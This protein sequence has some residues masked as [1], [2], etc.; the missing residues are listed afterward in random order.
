VT[1]PTPLSRAI[2]T[3]CRP[4][5]V[6]LVMLLALVGCKSNGQTDLVEREMRQQEDQ[7]YA[8]QDYLNNYQQLLCQT[9]AENEFLK[10]QL[11]DGQP[12]R[13]STAPKSDS[14]KSRIKSPSQ[15]P[16]QTPIPPSPKTNGP[17]LGDPEATPEVPKLD[18]DNPAVPP[19]R[20]T[21]AED[22]RGPEGDDRELAA[23]QKRPKHVVET[24]SYEVE[25]KEP[26]AAA[27]PM[28]HETKAADAQPLAP[29]E[30]TQQVIL[31]GQVVADEE[32]GS[33]HMLVDVQPQIASGQPVNFRGRLS[34]M[35]MDPNGEQPTPSLARW[36]FTADELDQATVNST[37]GPQFEFPLQLPSGV[38]TD[39]PVELWVRLLPEAGGKV[40]AHATVDLS[41][42][43]QF[44]SAGPPTA[45]VVQRAPQIVDSSVT[46]AQSIQAAICESG[47]Q[48]ARPDQ[49]APQLPNQVSAGSGWR[50]ATESIPQ[51]EAIATRV[52]SPMPLPISAR[53]PD[54]IRKAPIPKS[55]EWSPERANDAKPAAPSWSPTR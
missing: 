2:A 28:Q 43:C 8:M 1:H 10:Q 15:T 18:L 23:A 9:R 40:L 4:I 42:E 3:G 39:R 27:Q 19:L 26:A 5:L 52:E 51:V 21:S 47:W 35:V 14:A 13:M 45:P 38:P 12:A 34:L 29:A 17:Q 33:P 48:V 30:Q 31:Q 6:P 32:N 20:D 54:P 55:P 37:E 41:R 11:A 24:A 16:S 7:I 49:P 22:R 50:T 25:S 53:P 44:S 36:D 46:P